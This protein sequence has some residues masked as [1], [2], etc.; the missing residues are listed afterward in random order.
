MTVFVFAGG[1]AVNKRLIHDHLRNLQGKDHLSVV[2]I[3]NSFFENRWQ[4]GHDSFLRSYIKR[5]LTGLFDTDIS[6]INSSRPEDTFSDVKR[7]IQAD[8][9]SYRP[10]IVF[11]MIG[12]FDSNRAGLSE[13]TFKDQARDMFEY[14]AKNNIFV[15]V[16]TPVA[17]RD[18]VQLVNDKIQRLKMFNEIITFEAGH[19]NFPVIDVFGYVDRLRE[20]SPNDYKALF[21]D[22]IILSDKGCEYVMSYVFKYFDSAFQKRS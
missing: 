9:V 18:A 13:E 5:E 10:D 12:L 14:L 4:T 19:Q 6:V 22:Q 17:Y 3:G 1:C 21:Q 11:L 7:R 15:V 8:I 2:V 20:T 16:M